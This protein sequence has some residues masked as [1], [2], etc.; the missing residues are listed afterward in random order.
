LFTLQIKHTDSDVRILNAL[1]QFDTKYSLWG[2]GDNLGNVQIARSFPGNLGSYAGGKLAKTS[3]ERTR[4]ST[5]ACFVF[6]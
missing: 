2:G 6:F 4:V 5:F 3:S 1:P